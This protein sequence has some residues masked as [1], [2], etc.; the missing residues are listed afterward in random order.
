MSLLYLGG[1]VSIFSGT[2]FVLGSPAALIIPAAHLPLVDWFIRREERLLERQ[3][4]ETCGCTYR[5]WLRRWTY[6]SKQACREEHPKQ[7]KV[8]ASEVTRVEIHDDSQA[9]TTLS[10]MSDLFHN[11]LLFC[12]GALTLTHVA[13]TLSS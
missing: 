13:S 2:G 4:G 8:K 10:E 1:N 9:V 6:R 3:F 7:A 11:V 5:N 12:Y